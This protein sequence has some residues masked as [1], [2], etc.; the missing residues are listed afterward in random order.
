M[1]RAMI[2]DA[3]CTMLALPGIIALALIAC[4]AF[5]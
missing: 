3:I 5:S 2:I 1:N 4:A